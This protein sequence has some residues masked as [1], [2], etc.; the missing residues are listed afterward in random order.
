[1]HRFPRPFLTALALALSLGASWPA[2][3]ETTWQIFTWQAP[4]IGGSASATAELDRTGRLDRFRKAQAQLVDERLA[5]ARDIP[6]VLLAE[7]RALATATFVKDEFET[8]PDFQARIKAHN[9]KVRNLNDRIQAYLDSAPL[10]VEAEELAPITISTLREVYGDPVLG[11]VRY[12]A[13]TGVFLADLGPPALADLGVPDHVA[14]KA[15]LEEARVLKRQLLASR[16]ELTFEISSDGALRFRGAR[17]MVSDRSLALVA[18][19][20]TTLASAPTA[21]LAVLAP[22]V[23]SG[24]NRDWVVPTVTI[25]DPEVARLEK[26]VLER[27][28]QQAR[29]EATRR[30]KAELEAQLASLDSQADGGPDDL[31]PRLAQAALPTDPHRYAFVVGISRYANFPS[32]PFADRASGLFGRLATT[33]L[34]VPETNLTVLTD[35]QATGTG[36][37]G[38]FKSM[39][40]RVHP[41]DTVYVFYAGHGLPGKDGKDTYLVP[42]D[43]VEGAYEDPGLRLDRL[44][45]DL[46]A[47]RAGRI[48]VVLDS[49]FAGKASPKQN[50]VRDVAPIVV[51]ATGPAIDP[52]R[53]TLLLASGGDQF[54]NVYRDRSNRL[55]SYFLLKGLIDRP[56]DLQGAFRQAREEVDRRSRVLGAEY[57]QT[58]QIV[59]RASF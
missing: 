22:G 18:T 35:A 41:G 47:T 50:L 34:G 16:P 38:R 13:D 1:M 44:Y 27:R 4:A 31:G 9:A 40:N 52:A 29:E 56:D 8:T 17:V 6:P 48:V 46:E 36:I 33:R 25:Q 28:R 12:D 2:G 58:P 43:V 39:L 59:G 15:S 37:K 7:R 45:A 32:V 3:A 23:P 55:F 19:D 14:I 20:A 24:E 54:A 51:A 5:R 11:N 21:T 57:T 26:E 30:Q 53:T 42:H 49:C 10:R